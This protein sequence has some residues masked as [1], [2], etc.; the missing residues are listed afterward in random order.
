MN[1]EMIMKWIAEHEGMKSRSDYFD[2][3]R[4]TQHIVRYNNGD[5]YQHI[6][7]YESMMKKH[8]ETIINNKTVRTEGLEYH[9][10]GWKAT[11]TTL[12]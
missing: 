6:E 5:T 10:F 2:T 1:T 4:K 11:T 12:F 3:A 7:V 9:C 8:T